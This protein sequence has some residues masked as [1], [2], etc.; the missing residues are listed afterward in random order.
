MENTASGSTGYLLFEAYSSPPTTPQIVAIVLAVAFVAAVVGASIFGNVLHDDSKAARPPYSFARAQMMWWTLII[1]L[2]I[3]LYCGAMGDAPKITG[4]CLT[5]LGIGA[6]TTLTARI[7]DTR[8]RL[9]AEREGTGLTHLDGD[10][11][12][13]FEDLLSDENGISVHRFQAFVF[14]V[15]YGIAFLNTFARS[16]QFPVYD[17]EALAL[18]GISSAGYLGMKAFEAPKAPAPAGEGDE[19]LDATPVGG[20]LASG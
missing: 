12:G 6:A 7:I 13:F 15:I 8:Q 19:L 20:Q 18:L 10:S 2:A 4:T 17:V 11:Q 3:I 5:L 1:G 14:N 9:T 16:G